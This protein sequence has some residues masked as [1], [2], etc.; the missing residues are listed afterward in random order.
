[1][2]ERLPDLERQADGEDMPRLQVVASVV[3]QHQRNML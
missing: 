2:V 1:M 3:V